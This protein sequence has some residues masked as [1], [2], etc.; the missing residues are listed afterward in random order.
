MGPVDL[1]K[2]FIAYL[3]TL[4]RESCEKFIVFNHLLT[5]YVE[6]ITPPKTNNNNSTAGHENYF[7]SEYS[8]MCLPS[9][10]WQT[11]SALRHTCDVT[12]WLSRATDNS[13]F[14]IGSSEVQDNKRRLYYQG[15]ISLRQ[16]RIMNTHDK[17]I[18]IEYENSMIESRCLKVIVLDIM[19]HIFKHIVGQKHCA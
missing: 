17:I 12:L 10:L 11:V 14:F 8:Y 1:A 7:T 2:Q 16:Y 19:R 9:T 5:F 3:E 15:S 6:P 13:D 18:Y 4:C